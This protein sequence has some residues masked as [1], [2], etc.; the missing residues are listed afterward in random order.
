MRRVLRPAGKRHGLVVAIVVAIAVAACGGLRISPSPTAHV[1]APAA[2]LT[3]FAAASLRDALQAVQAAYEAANPGTTITISTDSSAALATRIEQGAPADV[4]VSADGAN[5]QQLVAAG[6]VEGAPV[7]VA[8]NTLAIVVPARNPAGIE[9]W[10]DLGDA[11]VRVIAAGEGVPI[12]RYADQLIDN[13]AGLPDAPAGFAAAYA[14]NV[15]SREDNVRA[16]VAKL[17]LGEGD[18][19]IVYATDARASMEVVAVAFP[20]AA[21]VS[22][23]YTAVVIRAS[24]RLTAA[25]AF[26][27]WLRGRDGQAL[28]AGFGFL[29]A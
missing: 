11:G 26:V 12:T 22:P 24:A 16:I 19:G 18:A 1:P 13:L 9:A 17:E 23:S 10:Q 4:F 14:A 21:N 29:P 2:N 6:R 7:V 3:V 25:E 27:A 5:P 8:R 28:L 20:A 15:V